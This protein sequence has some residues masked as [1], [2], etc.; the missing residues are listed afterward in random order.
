MTIKNKGSLL[1]KIYFQRQRTYFQW[2]FY[3]KIGQIRAGPMAPLFT[4]TF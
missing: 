2:V 3:Q 4:I 1:K